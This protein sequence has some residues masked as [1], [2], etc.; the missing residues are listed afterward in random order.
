MITTLWTWTQSADS[1]KKARAKFLHTRTIFQTGLPAWPWQTYLFTWG[2]PRMTAE[3]GIWILRQ[4]ISGKLRSLWGIFGANGL[5]KDTLFRAGDVSLLS[6]LDARLFATDCQ[7]ISLYSMWLKEKMTHSLKSV[8][9]VFVIAV[10][11][12]DI[13]WEYFCLWTVR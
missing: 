6:I 2:A 8:F 13:I 4:S 1:I 7:S 3:K 9:S 5:F 10:L 11:S 12:K